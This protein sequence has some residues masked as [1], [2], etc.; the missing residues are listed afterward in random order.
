MHFSRNITPNVIALREAVKKGEPREDVV[1]VQGFGDKLSTGKSA[2][3]RQTNISVLSIQ[4][5]FILF[6][7]F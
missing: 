2:G 3:K 4:H 6:S 7:R 5:V 1:M